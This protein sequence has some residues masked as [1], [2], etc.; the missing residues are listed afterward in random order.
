MP[1]S[2]ESLSKLDVYEKIL[3]KRKV[4]SKSD[5]HGILFTTWDFNL[6]HESNFLD[7]LGVDYSLT[8]DNMYQFYTDICSNILHFDE[9]Q[10]DPN[11]FSKFYDKEVDSIQLSNMLYKRGDEYLYIDINFDAVMGK[12]IIITVENNS[13]SL[14]AQFILEELLSDNQALVKEVHHRVKNN[15]QILLSLISIQERFKKNDA[16][17]K[18]YMKLSISSMAIMHSQLYS[19]NFTHVS[20]RRILLDLKSKCENLYNSENIT[21]NFESRNDSEVTIEKANP[22]LLLLDEMIISSI[23]A[24]ATAN[25]KMIDC[26]FNT[27]KENL[28]ILYK[29]NAQSKKEDDGLGNILIDSLISQ[30]DG[31]QENSIGSG[32]DFKISIPLDTA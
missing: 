2:N 6:I 18:E 17:I 28:T 15:L 29:D 14:E 7:I 31:R 9:I 24:L 10:S 20:T 16:S 21:F 23:D 3:S 1:E 32:Y 8:N 4:S 5:K 25:K 26:V 19:E 30:A 22:I 27:E 11:I 13:D 12:Y